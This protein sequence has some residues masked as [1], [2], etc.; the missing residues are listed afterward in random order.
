DNEGGYGAMVVPEKFDNTIWA[1]HVDVMDNT[2]ENN[3]VDAWFYPLICHEFAHIISLDDEQLTSD[4]SQQNL[5]VDYGMLKKEAYLNLFYEKF[6][7]EEYFKEWED[8]DRKRRL[9]DKD[10]DPN[11]PIQNNEFYNKHETDFVSKYAATN[12]SEDFADTFR[13]FVFLDEIP[14]DDTIAVKKINFMYEF[15]EFLEMRDKM[16]AASDARYKGFQYQW[17]SYKNN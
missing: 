3:K 11:K 13:W 1:M 7:G 8:E 15:P 5:K 9:Y 12:V 4:Y 16:R 14:T 10:Q 2:D 6:W 17:D